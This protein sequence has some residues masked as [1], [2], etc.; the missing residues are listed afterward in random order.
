MGNLHFIV[1]RSQAPSAPPVLLLDSA[2]PVLAANPGKLADEREAE[3]PDCQGWCPWAEGVFLR[4][5]GAQRLR[6]RKQEIKKRNSIGK[7]PSQDNK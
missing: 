5:G 2:L 7:M 1:W 4:R 3:G 6:R